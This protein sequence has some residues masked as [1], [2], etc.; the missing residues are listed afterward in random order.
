MSEAWV[1]LATSD[2]YALGALVLARSLAAAKTTKRTHCMITAN[3]TEPL[4][5]EL[6]SAFSTVT[7]VDVMDS[8]DTVNLALIGRPDLGVTFTKLHCWRLTQYT[9]CVFLD[10]DC[11]VLQNCDELFERDEFSAAADIGWPDC[12]NS[13]V[14]VFVP[15]LETYQSLLNFAVEHGSFDGGDQGLLNAYFHDWRDKPSAFRL[16]FIYNMTSGAIYTYAAAYKRFGSQ[17]KI[18]HFLGPVKPWQQ[19]CDT[20]HQS[21]HLAYW[22]SLFT[23]GV[24]P[25][26]PHVS[27]SSSSLPAAE[28]D[29]TVRT[30]TTTTIT[31]TTTTTTTSTLSVSSPLNST[32]GLLTTP[33]ACTSCAISRRGQPPRDVMREMLFMSAKQKY[34]R[35]KG[36]LKE[37]RKTMA[38]GTD[39]RQKPLVEPFDARCMQILPFKQSP[40][41]RPLR[42]VPQHLIDQ[43][44]ALSP[45]SSTRCL[46]NSSLP[47]I[48]CLLSTY[49][50]SSHHL[51]AIFLAPSEYVSNR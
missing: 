30:T 41:W 29:H 38:A 37:Q 46:S 24:A 31:T 9:K 45:V 36:I 14:F 43:M 19:N 49:L 17:I 23:R 42:H 6:R 34:L 28:P 39:R 40:Y 22:W 20:V 15:S 47:A 12:F 7:E 2:S 27:R 1:T 13:G 21:E 11:L 8:N 51:S 35:F 3:V 4:R 26:L 44:N 16:P 48:C 33:K 25:H 18:V 32:P 10:A 50:E 5:E